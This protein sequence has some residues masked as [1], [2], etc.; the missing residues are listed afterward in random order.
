MALH[1]REV[2]G[3]AVRIYARNPKDIRDLIFS[4][5]EEAIKN[6]DMEDPRLAEWVR[7]I[8][9]KENIITVE[10][11]ELFFQEGMVSVPDKNDKGP[12]YEELK[13]APDFTVFVNDESLPR[14]RVVR[15]N[16]PKLKRME[17]YKIQTGSMFPNLT[18]IP[19]DIMK[20]I[21]EFNLDSYFEKAR[22]NLEKL[23]TVREKLAEG[24]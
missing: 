22:E 20:A 17:L 16:F 2:K 7:K 6:G 18:F 19:E 4:Y 11:G 5:R 1:L 12:F 23:K 13:V 8:P 10:K 14:F 9:S 3:E 21:T 15:A 24:F